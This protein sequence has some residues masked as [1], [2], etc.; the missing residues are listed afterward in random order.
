MIRSDDDEFLAV[1]I[2]HVFRLLYNSVFAQDLI[3][4]MK[5]KHRLMDMCIGFFCILNLLTWKPRIIL[6]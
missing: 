6:R 1:S 3:F 2:A 4:S 5:C